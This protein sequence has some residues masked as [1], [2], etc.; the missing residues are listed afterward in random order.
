[1]ERRRVV[2]VRGWSVTT[3]DT[4]GQLPERLEA[5]ARSNLNLQLDVEHVFLSKYVSF[6]DEVKV[7]DLSRGFQAAL[8][9]Q[10]KLEAGERFVCVT[11]S[12]GGP[13]IRNWWQSHHPAEGSSCP[14]SHLVMLAPANFG[15]ALA[16][17]GKSR[18]SDIRAMFEGVEPGKGVLDWLE[19]GS[20]ESMA[21]NLEWIRRKDDV[22]AAEPPVFLFVLTGQSIDR[23]LFDHLNNYTGEMGSDGVV[24]AAAANLNAAYVKLVQ[25]PVRAAD[26]RAKDP[27]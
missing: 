7:D 1:M 27:D 16:Q 22:A 21:L 11:H 25:K 4:Y 8:E 19:L 14:M 6:H 10:V 23:G 15:S 12:T 9:R 13:V 24:R 2:F 5:E 20:P 3:T 18:L 26:V 17:L